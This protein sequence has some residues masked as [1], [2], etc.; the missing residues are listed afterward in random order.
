MEGALSAAW[1]LAAC[2]IRW[3]VVRIGMFGA[4][5]AGC[6][7]ANI[8]VYLGEL[9][10]YLGEGLPACSRRITPFVSTLNRTRAPCEVA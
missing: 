6:I 4:D 9:S 7:S 1:R 8:F 3:W 5:R 2:L 10:V